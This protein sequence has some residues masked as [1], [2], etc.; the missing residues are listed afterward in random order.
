[1]SHKLLT[2]KIFNNL[3]INVRFNDVSLPP[4]KFKFVLGDELLC[5]KWTKFVSLLSHLNG[6]QLSDLTVVDKL[7]DICVKLKYQ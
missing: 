5:D 2:M 1:M 7:N 4:T 6:Y 3:S